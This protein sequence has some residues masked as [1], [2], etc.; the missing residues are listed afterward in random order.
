[1]ED[2]K[3]EF[4]EAP[5]AVA[6]ANLAWSTSAKNAAAHSYIAGVLDA[7]RFTK[8]LSLA[9]Y[10]ALVDTIVYH[11]GPQAKEKA[12][13]DGFTITKIDQKRDVQKVWAHIPD[14]DW[15]HQ[16]TSGELAKWSADGQTVIGARKRETTVTEDDGESYTDVQWTDPISTAVIY[17]RY[18]NSEL[19]VSGRVT[20]TG[21]YKTT[22][23]FPVAYRNRKFDAVEPTTG[24]TVR[25]ILVTGIHVTNDVGTGTFVAD[26]VEP[27]AD[28]AKPQ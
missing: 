25:G 8:A 19:L 28:A 20:I 4:A 18:I 22:V 5:D 17:P 1:M 9:Q 11:E 12:W 26:V 7:L 15:S 10:T 24:C 21:E 3:P 6:F 16:L 2:L 13:P 23:G 27:V 14:P